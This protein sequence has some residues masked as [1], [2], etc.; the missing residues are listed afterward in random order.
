MITLNQIAEYFENALNEELGEKN[1]KF[2]IWADVGKFDKPFRDGNTVTHY[3]TGNLRT[4]SSSNDANYLVMGTNGLSLDFAIPVKPPRTTASESAQELLEVVDGQYPFVIK[5]VAAI[6]NYFQKA[7]SFTLSDGEDE[8]SLS[9]QAGTSVSGIVDIQSQ[10]G[11]HVTASVYIQLY[12][13]KGGTMSNDVE[14]TF[15]GVR[16]P[17]QS[18]QCGRSTE[19][20]R[21]V[22]A[23]REISKSIASSSAFS[24]DVKFPV[25][26]DEISKQTLAF[27]FEGKPNTAHFVTVKFGKKATEEGYL[28]TVDNNNSLSQGVAISGM[29][30]SLAEVVEATETLNYPEGFQVGR[31]G[32]EN[33]A[34]ES[35]TLSFSEPCKAYIGGDIYFVTEGTAV[36]I[37]LQSEDFIYDETKDE[38]YVYVITDKAVN[39]QG[40]PVPF[41]VV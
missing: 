9:F 31:F 21:D 18:V 3:I 23:G 39:V 25:N 26:G 40:G 7:Q 24:I 28:M 37:S 36:S 35:I 33:S 30:A 12:F 10:L 32:L 8:Y 20:S 34:L 14:V 38:Y 6:N 17:F 16:V 27:L 15:D 1:I 11:K 4:T 13:I 19:S 29:S 5:V 22:Y 41:E 2:H